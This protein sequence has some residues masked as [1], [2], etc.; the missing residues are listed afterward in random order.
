MLSILRNAEGG[1][2]MGSCGVKIDMY[3]EDMSIRPCRKFIWPSN[4]SIS[5]RIRVNSDSIDRISEM[6]SALAKRSRKLIS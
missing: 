2:G 6:V 4:L 5:D 1:S 3:I